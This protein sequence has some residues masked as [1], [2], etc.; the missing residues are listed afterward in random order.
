MAQ[1]IDDLLEAVARKRRGAALATSDIAVTA[2]AG[3]R[4]RHARHREYEIDGAGR[5]RGTRHPTKLRVL[6]FLGDHQAAR[7][8]DRPSPGAAVIAGARENDA[9]GALT[10]RRD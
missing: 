8:L 3:E 10:E 6:R 4:L 7:L 5:D 1:Q 9:D 2:V